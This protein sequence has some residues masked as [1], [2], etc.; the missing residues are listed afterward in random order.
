[1]LDL[2][3]LGEELLDGGVLDLALVLAVD[4]VADEDEGE[5]LGLLGGALV[6]ELGDPGLDVVEGL[7]RGAVTRLL[8]MS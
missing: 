8:V 5:L 7:A 6:E 1:M 3:V 2:G 4:L